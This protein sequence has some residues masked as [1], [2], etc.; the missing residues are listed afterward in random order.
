MV[1]RTFRVRCV[2]CDEFTHS[3]SLDTKTDFIN[4]LLDEGW[5]VGE[6]VDLFCPTCTRN[7]HEMDTGSG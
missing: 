2:S 1:E 7:D 6:G 4:N 5:T 3:H